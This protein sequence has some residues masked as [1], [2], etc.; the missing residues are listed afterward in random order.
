MLLNQLLKNSNKVVKNKKLFKTNVGSNFFYSRKAKEITNPVDKKLTLEA[1]LNDEKCETPESLI[2]QGFSLLAFN[3]VFK[4]DAY[5]CFV[6]AGLMTK[7]LDEAEKKSYQKYIDHGIKLVDTKEA[8]YISN[9]YALFPLKLAK[10]ITDSFDRM[11]ML[12][13]SLNI[14]NIYKSPEEAINQGFAYLSFDK[15]IFYM[16]AYDCFLYAKRLIKDFDE[17]EKE[18]YQKHIDHGE[19]LCFSDE[20]INA[21][22]SRALDPRDPFSP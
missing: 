6:E 20:K 9:C 5:D 1:A 2:N 7:K 18:S 21:S 12:T 19:N 16:R 14:D 11:Q 8:I 17:E 22:N 3:S 4:M 10:E 13:D 15:K